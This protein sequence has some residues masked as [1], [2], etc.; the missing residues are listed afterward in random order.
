MTI[1]EAGVF[2]GKLTTIILFTCFIFAIIFFNRIERHY[3]I[4]A[5][6]I[7]IALL[8]DIS[9]TV[10]GEIYGNNLIL[11]PIFALAELSL[12]AILFGWFM[13]ME[14]YFWLII[15]IGGLGIS[16]IL[17][18]CFTL[19]ANH[20]ETFQTYSRTVDAFIIVGYCMLFYFDKLRKGIAPSDSRLK[21]STIVLIF[22][23]FNLIF[24]LPMNFLI[25]QRQAQIIFYFWMFY[26]IIIN[27]FYIYIT[28]AL[29]KNGKIPKRLRSGSE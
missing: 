29:W 2:L 14:R 6:Y 27:F 8:G 23:S 5:F 4:M 15:G 18:E 25:S 28:Y 26:L 12:F 22:F 24:L 21:L 9:M 16:F 19:D 17:Y 1:I 3:K 7:L 13:Q 10:I 11:F 20:P